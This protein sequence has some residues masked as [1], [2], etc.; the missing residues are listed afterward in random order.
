MRIAIDLFAQ[1]GKDRIGIIVDTT[2]EDAHGKGRA[3]LHV[4]L[5]Q[6]EEFLNLGEAL[7]DIPELDYA[8]GCD[9]KAAI[10]PWFL[11]L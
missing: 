9:A 7:L 5:G 1:Q 11:F 4:F 8:K 10:I 6:I 2:S 3:G